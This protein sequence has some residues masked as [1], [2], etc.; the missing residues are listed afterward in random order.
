ME[1]VVKEVGRVLAVGDEDAL[2]LVV[3]DYDLSRRGDFLFGWTLLHWVVASGAMWALPVVLEFVKPEDVDMV[4]EL[5]RTPL[6]E[7]VARDLHDRNELC[8]GMVK[9]LVE[10]RANPLKADVNGVSAWKYAYDHE[11]ED[12]VEVLS[13]SEWMEDAD[14]LG[15]MMS[16]GKRTGCLTGV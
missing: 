12:I 2:R 4:D 6:R 13:W 16:Q 3:K 1:D 8:L 9:L 15:T 5:G 10:A 7:A 14:Y 11:F